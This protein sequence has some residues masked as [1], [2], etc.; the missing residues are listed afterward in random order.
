MTPTAT[1]T[2]SAPSSTPTSASGHYIRVLFGGQVLKSSN[3]SLGLI[4]M[5]PVETLLAYFD[6]LAGKGASLVV[7]KCNS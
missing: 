3:P 2:S 6:G 1:T 7:Q 5:L 4:D